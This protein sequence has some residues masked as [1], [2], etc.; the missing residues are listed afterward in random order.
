MNVGT[1]YSQVYSGVLTRDDSRSLR[2]FDFFVPPGATDV[3]VMLVYS[4]RRED[5]RGALGPRDFRRRWAAEI[6][7]YRGKL[8]RVGDQDLLAFFERFVDGA[9][10]RVQPLQNLLNLAIFDSQDHFRGRWDSPQ[11]FGEWVRIGEVSA[12]RGFVAGDVPPGRWTIVLECHAV[13]TDVCS[14]EIGVRCAV[15]DGLWLRGELHA[16]TNHSDG[17]LT[18]AGL[19]EAAREA[20]L[21][22][23][24][25]T[26]HN[27]VSGLA[28][29]GSASDSAAK[30]IV[31]PGM[32]LTTFYGHAVA[33]GVCEFI[34]WHDASKGD[35]LNRQ[36]REVRRLGGLFSVA[37][38]F[39]V[40]YPV[41][42][43]CEWEYEDT[44][45]GLVDLMEVWSGPWTSHVMWNVPAMRW[46]D[47]LLCKG[48]RVTGVAARDAHKREQ[49]FERETADTYVWAR[50]LTVRDVLEGLRSGRVYISSGPRLNFS[51]TVSGDGG[52]FLP[53][54]R[55]RIP[56]GARLALR[57]ELAD[58]AGELRKS[59]RWGDLLARV[60]KGTREHGAHAVFTSQVRCSG[61]RG[62]RGGR[63]DCDGARDCDG[64]AE[65]IEF[66]DTTV[67]DA[68]YRCEILVDG[69]SRL[70]GPHFIAL[71]NPIF[72]E[73]ISSE[74]H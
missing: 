30:P 6:D 65:P 20:G 62:D 2:R 58:P 7:R 21:D 1:G 10:T 43:G 71:T 39:S 33:L 34:P 9:C 63:G 68:W 4:P 18:P 36:A 51:L 3:F 61:D 54:D 72:V 48:Y 23:I 57:V 70:P 16:H 45:P 40:G 41:C 31:I 27:T 32:E 49:L 59:A 13:V 35:G 46:W 26:D 52:R 17:A 14:F 22:F 73:V 37:H 69:K 24:A 29:L 28:E 56:S 8:E 55:A 38:P 66:E 67:G 53:G 5:E 19:V 12:T 11:H 64:S 60:V 50:S 15:S 25:I 44:D 47:D 74:A 42:A